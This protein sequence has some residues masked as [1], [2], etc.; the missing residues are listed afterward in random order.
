MSV[1]LP[2]A[3]SAVVPGAIRR[4]RGGPTP[5]LPGAVR[6]ALPGVFRLLGSLPV[7][8]SLG[9]QAAVNYYGYATTPRPR[10]LTLATDYPT[11]RTLTDRRWT[12]RHLPPAGPKGPG[13]LAGGPTSSGCS[14]AR[15]R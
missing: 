9:T 4:L 1:L 7:V 13:A 2:S 5:E 8:R 11:W 15:A 12:G 3:L 10:E 6:D 14:A